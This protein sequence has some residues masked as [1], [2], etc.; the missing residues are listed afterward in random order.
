MDALS[1]VLRL[2]RLTG[3]VFLNAEVTAPWAITTM[4]AREI[5]EVLMPEAQHVIEYHLI[6]EGRCFI[7]VGNDAPI[8]LVQ[9]DLVMVPHGDRH[10]MSSEAA[11]TVTPYDGAQMRLPSLGEIA[12]PRYGG[13]GA[14]SR[15]VCGFLAIDRRLCAALL[16]ALPSVL[17]VSS[18]GSE[19]SAWLQSYVRIRLVERAEEQPGGAGVL[20]K[21]SE[22]MFLEAIRRY[23]ECLPPGQSGWLAGLKD[24]CVGKALSLIHSQPARAWTVDGLAREIGISRAGLADRFSGL[25]GRSPIQYLTQWRLTL[26]AHLLQTTTKSACV[27]AYEV[28][29]ESEAAFNRAFRREHG[30]PPATWR[31]GPAEARRETGVQDETLETELLESAA[32]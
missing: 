6:V 32:A 14:K 24:P 26:A 31:K 2:V 15:I 27:V 9:G 23:V 20:A 22:L 19:L 18:A 12:T 25:I 16:D 13:G 8:E 1:E 10:V 29:Y 5:G 28:G 17:R 4:S 3:A 21:L 30:A 7:R 11:P